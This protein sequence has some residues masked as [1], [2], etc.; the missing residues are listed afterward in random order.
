MVQVTSSGA[1]PRR[2]SEMTYTFTQNL[3]KTL[4]RDRI[5]DTNEDESEGQHSGRGGSRDMTN[6][7]RGGQKKAGEPPNK[8]ELRYPADSHASD[9]LTEPPSTKSSSSGT[10]STASDELDMTL[11]KTTKSALMFQ[12]RLCVKE[13]IFRVVKFIDIPTMMPFD[14]DPNS[15]CGIVIKFCYTE[16]LTVKQG[17][18]FWIAARPMVT[19]SHTHVRNNYIKG[20]QSVYL[21]KL[22]SCRDV[23]QNDIYIFCSLMQT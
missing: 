7:T 23:H 18:K 21:G 19:K 16:E 10:E 12:V 6:G 15:L 5:N 13:Q 17:A 8:I 4:D 20:M 22:H 2:R 1:P 11:T 9:Q 3:D 14:M